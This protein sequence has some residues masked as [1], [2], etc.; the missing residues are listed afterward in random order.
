MMNETR[1]IIFFGTGAHFSVAV[2]RRLVELDVTPCAMVIPEYPAAEPMPLLGNIDLDVASK[3]P[4]SKMAETM[5]VPLLFA[6]ASNH[7]LL[8]GRLESYA[9]EFILV[10]C[11]PYLLSSEIC[12]TASK[13][14][15]NLH[16]SL[17][18]SYRGA[19][20]VEAQLRNGV[21]QLGVSLHLLNQTFD[22]GDIVSQSRIE[23]E[24]KN[25]TVEEIEKQTARV[26]AELFVKALDA[27]G[28]SQWQPY[29]QINSESGST[30]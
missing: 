21:K 3:K 25:L 10:A 27:Y 28:T 15:L 22:S 30:V 20:P 12:L 24:D 2:L 7:Q 26:G 6:P 17:L 29:K 4:L 5:N 16:P 8:A 11:W 9:A 18:P 1:R 19:N 13:A 23:I 14:A